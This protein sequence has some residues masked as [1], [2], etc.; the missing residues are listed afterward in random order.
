MQNLKN[1]NF[2]KILA[3]IFFIAGF[4][5]FGTKTQAATYYLALP[6]AGHPSGGPGGSGTIDDPWHDLN[7]AL[8]KY[9]NGGT[10]ARVNPGDTLYLRGGTYDISTMTTPSGYSGPVLLPNTDINSDRITIKSCPGE[11]AVLDGVGTKRILQ[12]PSSG[13][14]YNITFEDL[15]IKNG[16]TEGLDFRS[17]VGYGDVV[18]QGAIFRNIYFHDNTDSNHDN[19]PA[20]LIL[21]GTNCIIEYCTFEDNGTPSDSHLNSANLVLMNSYN[22]DLGAVDPYPRKNNIVRYNR[23]IGSAIGIKDKG[24]SNFVSN[25]NVDSGSGLPVTTHPEWANEIYNN[26]F[27][28]QL[29]AGYYLQQDYVSV[30]NNIFDGQSVSGNK[31]VYFDSYDLAEKV[32]WYP[33]VCNNTFVNNADSGIAVEIN[34]NY[35]YGYYWTIKN[36][37]FLG[38]STHYLTY[39]SGNT[40][41]KPITSN[42][43]GLNNVQTVVARY[44]NYG[45]IDFESL[46][47][48]GLD[49]NS[50]NSSLAV[51]NYSNYDYRLPTGS[52]AIGAGESGADL[53]AIAYGDSNWATT[54]GYTQTGAG[55]TIPPASPSGLSVN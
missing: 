26:L 13:T 12:G 3:A 20:G 48:Y 17:D 5:V 2:I 8:N 28:G 37:L 45:N 43:N 46:R 18:M 11:W 40:I 38:A 34:P 1:K 55:D 31:G 49:L 27:L 16:L 42:Y 30:H 25:N 10:N 51:T 4:F 47:G 9:A 29:N 44:L 35:T 50:I 7:Y 39:L 14:V 24:D 54:T 33:N 21:A 53:G 19:N 6:D 36:N 15:E 32:V 22:S 52:A 41:N 23:F